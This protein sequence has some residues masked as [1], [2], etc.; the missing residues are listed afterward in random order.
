MALNQSAL[1]E[2][3]A[4][5]KNGDS[6]DLVRYAAEL[7][8]QALIEAEATAKIGAG[9]YERSETR[10]NERNGYRE[11]TLTTKAGDLNLKIPKLR[12]G[13]FFPSMLEP[14]R[15]I[16]QALY[17]VVME[18][19]VLGVST[20]SVDELVEALG[21]ESGISRSEVSR[22]CAGLDEQVAAFFSRRLDHAR[23]PYVILDATY[24]HVREDHKV[25]S[26]AVVIATGINASGGREVLGMAVGDSEEEAFWGPF[27]SGLRARGLSGVQLVISDQHAGLV[28]AIRRHLQGAAHQRCR[29]HAA[30][31]LLTHVPKASQEMVAAAFRTIFAQAGPEEVSAQWDVV[32]DSL[33]SKFDKAAKLMDG[34]KEEVLAF[35]AFPREHWRQIWSTNS[36]ERLNKELKRRCRVVGIFPNEASVMRLAGSV[37]IDAHDEWQ[38]SERR[39]FS[40]ESMAKAGRP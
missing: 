8:L 25:V 18:A 2:I 26:K 32:R 28:A 39:Y 14:R 36:L 21:I 24:L 1:D 13:S 27:L 31:N 29:V 17:A 35:S 11:R 23:F 19:Y 4:M 30:R 12:Q 38:A 10:S 9:R 15:R 37:L 34:A 40:L 22:I 7:L 33:A 3:A 5:L 16:D 20:R 6:F